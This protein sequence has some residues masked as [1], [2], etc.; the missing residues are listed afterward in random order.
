MV[1]SWLRLNSYPHDFSM[2]PHTETCIAP[3][4]RTSP[5]CHSRRLAR[6]AARAL[7]PTR[8]R[9]PPLAPSSS[10]AAPPHHAAAAHAECTFEHGRS[11]PRV[12]AA[13]RDGAG[14]GPIPVRA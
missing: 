2:T 10:L 9:N 6:T 14:L 12:A 3:I 5:G 11:V 13:P 4:S 1:G 7:T 8:L